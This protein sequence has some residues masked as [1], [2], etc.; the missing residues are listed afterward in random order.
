MTR[1]SPAAAGLLAA[2]AFLL[3]APRSA[4]AA[5]GPVRVLTTTTDLAGIVR[6]VGGAR[7]VVDSLCRVRRI[8]TSSTRALRSSRWR[9]APSSSS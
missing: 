1:I 8:R 2:F 3:P 6:A 7:V 9:I 4:R 5:D